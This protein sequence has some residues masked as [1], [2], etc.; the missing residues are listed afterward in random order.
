M[1]TVYILY[2][3]KFQKSYVGFTSSLEE[4]FKS[5]NELGKKGWTIKFRP[6]EI[7]HTEPF[8]IKADAMKRELFLKSG[9]GR[10]QV[11]AIIANWL[12]S[13]I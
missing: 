7:A 10:I 11:K 9:Q 8:D 3:R 12:S 5:H 1:Y 2:S 4:R 6:W 13:K